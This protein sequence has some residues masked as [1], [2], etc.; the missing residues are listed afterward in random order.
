VALP[1]A[2]VTRDA[3]VYR[4]LFGALM[5]L[6]LTL[7]LI[8]CLRMRKHLDAPP[9]SDVA[10]ILWS[11]AAVAAVGVVA[12]HRYDA[13]LS[14]LLCAMCQAAFARRPALLGVSMG[15][16]I[17]AK[18]VPILVAPLFIVHLVRDRRWRE[19][20]VASIAA[21]ITALAICLPVVIVAG[22]G[23]LD[24]LRYH[25]E[26]PI[27]IESTAAA[28]LALWRLVDPTSLDVVRSFGSTNVD[29]TYTAFALRLLSLSTLLGIGAIYLHAWR[30][31]GREPD[32]RT[33]N[34]RLVE[35]VLATLAVF[36]VCGKVFS[37]QYLVWLIP[38]GMLVSLAQGGRSPYFFTLIMICTQVIFPATYGDLEDL[39][40][41]SC[42]L[43]L[44]R[45]GLLLAFAI[46]LVR[47]RRVPQLA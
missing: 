24:V 35:Y 36:M 10:I 41:F 40:P 17:A 8:A 3:D 38:L 5:A 31:L 11:A 37:P 23:L 16:A 9:I 25:G 1:V 21:T 18:A 47:N 45:N 20:W 27:Q 30:H 4:V 39:N 15:L 2:L 22:R 46:N 6:L 29:G 42:A 44:A 14:F 12:T 28:I 34:R 13:V 32:A 19:L 26:R 33:H 7:A 43:V